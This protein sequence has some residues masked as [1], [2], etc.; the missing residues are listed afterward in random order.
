[1]ADEDVRLALEGYLSSVSDRV[2]DVVARR[3]I[4]I[5]RARNRMTDG[6]LVEAEQFFGE[7]RRL[8]TREQ[9]A[10]E[11]SEERDRNTSGDPAV[12]AK[13]NKLVTES[14][15]TLRRFLDPVPIEKLRTE[16]NQAARNPPAASA[17]APA[18]TPEAPPPAAATAA[19]PASP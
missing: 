6:K 18:A 1:V 14:Q 8:P 2:V 3:E 16:L 5:A 17:P 9:I 10:Q 13:L 7:L 19:A 4:L 11:I 15:K 12:Q